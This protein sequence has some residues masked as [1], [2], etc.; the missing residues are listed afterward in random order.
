MNLYKDTAL[1]GTGMNSTLRDLALFGTLFTYK[2]AG[3]VISKKVL[4]IIVSSEEGMPYMWDFLA[5]GGMLKG[6]FGKQ[7]LYVNPEL[8]L[9]CAQ[10]NH[11]QEFLLMNLLRISICK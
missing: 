6:G 7:I 5:D 3:E 11:P 1:A 8:N 10:F 2:R 4:E 9:V